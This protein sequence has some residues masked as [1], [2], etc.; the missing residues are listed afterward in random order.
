[1]P[2]GIPYIYLDE[3]AIDPQPH[4]LVLDAYR[5]WFVLG[6]GVVLLELVLVNQTGLT[7]IRV[8]YQSDVNLNII[9]LWLLLLLSLLHLLLHEV[10]MVHW[11]RHWLC[12][13]VVY[14]VLLSCTALIGIV[15]WLGL[16][17]CFHL[18]LCCCLFR[19]L[20]HYLFMMD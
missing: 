7:H 20:C 6:Q 12:L 11:T 2:R 4:Y 5:G 17:E 13:S 18:V 19:A 1:M 14:I 15:G 10:F 9:I 16:L 8:T 3:E